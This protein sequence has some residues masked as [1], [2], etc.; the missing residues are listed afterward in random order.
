VGRGTSSTLHQAE[1]HG[2]QTKGRPKTSNTKSLYLKRVVAEVNAV[3][4]EYLPLLLQMIRSYRENVD[5]K[6]AAES[7]QKGWQEAK[8]GESVLLK[9]LW[10]GIHGE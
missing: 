6:P 10:V 4:E 2:P 3:P 5:L 8:A 7:F 1:K 9:H